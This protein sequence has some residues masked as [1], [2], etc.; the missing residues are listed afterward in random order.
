MEQD[1]ACFHERSELLRGAFGNG[2]FAVEVLFLVFLAE[3]FAEELALFEEANC[4]EDVAREEAG[5]GAARF[6]GYRFGHWP[7]EPCLNQ[8][9]EG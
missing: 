7:I 8:G 3:D 1:L 2:Y 4:I 9:V 5:A 6:R